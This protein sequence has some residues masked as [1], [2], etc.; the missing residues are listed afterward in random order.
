MGK[1]FDRDEIAGL[2]KSAV[3]GR[4]QA[5]S[6]REGVVVSSHPIV[7]RIARDVLRDGGNAV[8]AV[9]AASLAQTVV[10]PHMTT[11]F[12]V[13]SMMHYDAATGA[14]QYVNG[15]MNAPLAGLPGYSAADIA[16]GRSVAVPGFWSAWEA[17]RAR[18]ARKS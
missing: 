17:S 11:A 6:G 2:T 13:L 1:M 14:T 3:F 5:A 15:S 16:T 10:E 7:S 4:K 9:L 18:Y 12:G 8:D